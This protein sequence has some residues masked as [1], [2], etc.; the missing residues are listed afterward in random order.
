MVIWPEIPQGRRMSSWRRQTDVAHGSSQMQ[1]YRNQPEEATP[2]R[3]TQHSKQPTHEHGMICGMRYVMHMQDL[4]RNDWT[5]P[6]LGNP[7]V[8]LERWGD[9]DWNRYKDHRNLMHSL[10]MASKTNMA[11][12]CDN[13]QVAI[14]MHQDKYATALKH[15]KKIHG[16]DPIMML[17]KR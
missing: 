10:K 6:Q 14:L 5:W 11:R 2:E 16:R 12:V 8:P 3:S 15:D 17:D 7:R 9:F 1:R 4:T 13:Q